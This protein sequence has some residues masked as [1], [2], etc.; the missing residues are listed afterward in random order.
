MDR[1]IRE[2]ENR[3]KDHEEQQRFFNKIGDS[4]TAR[5]YYFMIKEDEWI[6]RMLMDSKN[7]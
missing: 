3:I 7:Q 4:I 1:I 5:Q 6:L 2:V